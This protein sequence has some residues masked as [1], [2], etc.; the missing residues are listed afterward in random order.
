MDPAADEKTIPEIPTDGSVRVMMLVKANLGNTVVDRRGSIG[1]DHW[2]DKSWQGHGNSIIAA[3]ETNSYR[4]FIV[5]Q[6]QAQAKY[7]VVYWP[8][9]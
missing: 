8:S 4:E 3:K 1:K 5:P 7:A 9:T 6:G 2:K